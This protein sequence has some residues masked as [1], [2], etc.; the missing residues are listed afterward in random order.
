MKTPCFVCVISKKEKKT[1]KNYNVTFP[2]QGRIHPEWKRCLQGIS[3]TISCSSNSSKHTGHLRP[4]SGTKK[5]CR[6]TAQN[7]RTWVPRHRRWP[8][9]A[10]SGEMTTTLSFWTAALAAGGGRRWFQ[11]DRSK[12]PGSIRSKPCIR[13]LQTRSVNTP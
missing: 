11:S 7:H 4:L 12:V 13:D 5:N 2:N 10:C 3:R 9:P 6:N 8:S 1:P